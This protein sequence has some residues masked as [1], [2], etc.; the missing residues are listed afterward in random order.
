M[1]L[2][3]FLPNYDDPVI[4]TYDANLLT[5]PFA[6][7]ILRTHPVVIVGN[8]LIENSFFTSPQDFIREVQSRTGPSQSYRA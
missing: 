6:V 3:E 4:C 8:I 1:R 7:D 2:N 5:A